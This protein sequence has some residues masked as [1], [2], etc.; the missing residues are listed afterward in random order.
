MPLEIHTME[1]TA[2]PPSGN[3]DRVILGVQVAVAYLGGTNVSTAVTWPTALPSSYA[4]FVTPS[5]AGTASV[6]SK[7]SS[8]FNV[9]LTG[10][11]TAGTMDIM[12]IA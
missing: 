7:T 3:L 11:I 6:N 9:L 5:T 10:T 8:G 12:V 2:A 1:M 4:V